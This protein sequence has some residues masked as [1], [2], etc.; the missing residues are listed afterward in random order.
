L[1]KLN[2]QITTVEVGVKSL[3]EVTIFPLSLADQTKTARIL[4]KAF[5]EVM[6][7]LSSFGEDETNLEEESLASMAK[8]LSDIDVMEFVVSAIQDNLGVILK[9]VVDENEMISMEE[10]TNDQFYRLVEI[11][12]EVNYEVAPKN[13]V[14]LWKRALGIVSP[15]KK[16]KKKV[17]HSKKP[18]QQSAGN[19]TTG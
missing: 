9:L 15:E 4:A 1:G 16:I 11:I 7:K 6:E 17:P 5:Q 14:A 10:L 18:S 19:I 8:Q 13:F 12:Y 2:P 3:R